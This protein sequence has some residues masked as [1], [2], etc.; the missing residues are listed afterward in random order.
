M[1]RQQSSQQ[2]E[3]IL[4]VC[5]GIYNKLLDVPEHTGNSNNLERFIQDHLKELNDDLNLVNIQRIPSLTKKYTSR[6]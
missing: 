5:C 3:Q 4:N 1:I 2:E 6:G